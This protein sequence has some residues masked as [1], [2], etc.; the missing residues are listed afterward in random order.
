MAKLRERL[1]KTRPKQFQFLDSKIEHYRSLR[2]QFA[3]RSTQM[4]SFPA[5][6]KKDEFESFLEKLDGI[7]LKGSYW[8]SRENDE[9]G[10]AIPYQIA[11][12]K[13]L[14]GFLSEACAYYSMILEMLYPT[15]GR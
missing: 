14:L 1:P 2:H 7:S 3:H 13:F 15:D 5:T 4:F 8:V 9:A 10:V 6:S 11:S 12:D